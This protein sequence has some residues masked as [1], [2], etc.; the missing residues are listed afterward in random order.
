[1]HPRIS[2]LLSHLDAERD[3][4][5]RVVTLIPEP[6]RDR[7]VADDEWTV[8]EV[9]DHLAL[10]EGGVARLVAKRVARAREDGSVG[11]EA[12]TGSVLGALDR[13]RVDDAS[14]R[15]EAPEM[16]RPRPGV[17]ATDAH[18]ALRETR[19][20]L[21]EAVEAGDGLALGRIVV[22]HTALGDIDLYQWILFVAQHERRHRTQLERIAARLDEGG[23]SAAAAMGEA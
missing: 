6:A 14:A 18:A 3:A 8:A 5:D 21:R 17:R 13:Y 2:E 16:V 12:D 7:R 1:M 19:R 23:E 10:V 11:A 9:L 20:A 4:L 22:P 15:R